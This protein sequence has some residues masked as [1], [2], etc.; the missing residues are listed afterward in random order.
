MEAIAPRA[1]ERFLEIGPGRGALTLPLLAAGVRLA[2]VEIDPALA[3]RLR[4]LAGGNDRLT[5]VEGDILET[6]LAAILDRSLPPGRGVRIV[7]N[8]PYSV[9]SPAILRLLNRADRFADLTLMVQREVADRILSPPGRRDYG[10]LTLLCAFHARAVRLLDLPPSSF[11]PPPEVHSTLLRFLPLRPPL[12][13]APD[14]TAFE[15]VVKAAFS[16][17]RKTL[18]N[19]LARALGREVSEIETRL[20]EADLAPRDRP[21]RIDPEGFLRLAR[22]LSPR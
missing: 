12:A 10:V 17:R 1:G 16:E 13:G 19:S 4:D 20:L 9:A 14:F 6:D 21:E 5:I 3:R 7:G 15:K 18:R 11:S 22:I 8:L 2:A